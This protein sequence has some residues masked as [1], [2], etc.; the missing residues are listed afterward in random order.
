MMERARLNTAARDLVSHQDPISD[1][2]KAETVPFQGLD[3]VYLALSRLRRRKFDGAIEVATELLSRNALDQQVCGSKL[4]LECRA[5][6][7]AYS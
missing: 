7:N 5:H 4:A 3:P 1:K 2:W 6:A